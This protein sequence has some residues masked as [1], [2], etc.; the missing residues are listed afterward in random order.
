MKDRYTITRTNGCIVVEGAVP[1][2]DLVA[3]TRAWEKR[4]DPGAPKW[5]ADLVLS[6][7]LRCNMVFGPP[8]ACQAWRERLGVAPEGPPRPRY[9]L[10]DQPFPGIWC[11]VCDR[12]SYNANDIKHRYCGFCKVYLDYQ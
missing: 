11:R 5:I 2:D 3:L 8:E 12:T 10:V 1:V 6:S 7:H 9:E 4:E